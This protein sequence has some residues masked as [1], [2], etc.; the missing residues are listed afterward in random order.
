MT[1]PPATPPASSAASSP[2]VTLDRVTRTFGD[3]VALDD[4]SLDL[5]AGQ[6]VGML[7]PNGAGKST[8]L[9][10]VAGLRRPTSGT[11]R[12]MGR[13]PRD[14][15]ARIGLGTTPQ[16]TGLP[17]TLRVREVIDFVAGHFPDPMPTAEVMDMFGL[18]DLARR[19]TGSLSG[20]QKRR[21][22][23]ALSIVGRPRVV[24]L[25]EPTTGLDVDARRVLWDAVQA[26][27]AGGAAIVVTSHYL[28]E[29]EALAQRV[30]VVDGG[31]I[32]ADDDLASV[33]SRVGSRTVRFRLPDASAIAD[34]GVLALL[35]H[36]EREG[37]R[38]TVVTPEADDLVRSLVAADV[39][40]TGLDVRGATLEEAFV[41]MT[42]PAATNTVTTTNG[43]SAR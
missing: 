37:D 38:W 3:V 22:A 8:L 30:V 24:L 34:A 5:H 41:A 28:E 32:L 16:E 15:V 1:A 20:G 42:S 21:L 25:D 9:S 33:L 43:R 12:L 31:R 27:H 39:P 13:D 18:G 40:F 35:E 17:A 7:G 4:V 19:Q 23:V 10:L 6:L 36:A 29:I 11:V 26:Y 14:P 2:V